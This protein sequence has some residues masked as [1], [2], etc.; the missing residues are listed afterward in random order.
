[1]GRPNSWWQLTAGLFLLMGCGSVASGRY[2][3]K[4]DDGSRYNFRYLYD[5]QTKKWVNRECELRVSEKRKLPLP[6][7]DP[8]HGNKMSVQM[9]GSQTVESAYLK[10][11]DFEVRDRYR[12][13][14]MLQV[15]QEDDL[16]GKMSYGVSIAWHHDGTSTEFDPMEI[17]HLPPPGDTP[18]DQ[19]S[20]WVRAGDQ[21]EGAFGW[22]SE[23]QGASPESI[24][25]PEY[26]FEMRCKLW[27]A[28]APG[29][30]P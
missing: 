15:M 14:H 6:L 9:M 2:R 24:P 28:D 13:W 12:V 19:W 8:E 27:L 25:P 7:T 11:L 21:R 18:P 17:F 4:V 26:P 29:I 10:T 20:D 16:A 3:M 5:T 22:W 30:L 1:M 23:V